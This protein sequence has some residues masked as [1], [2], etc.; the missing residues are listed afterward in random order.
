MWHFNSL[1]INHVEL[2]NPNIQYHHLSLIEYWLTD[3]WLIKVIAL[4]IIKYGINFRFTHT[5]AANSFLCFSKL[6]LLIQYYYLSINLLQIPN[7]STTIH[8]YEHPLCV[9][10]PLQI[11]KRMLRHHTKY[12]PTGFVNCYCDV[13]TTKA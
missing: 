5:Q 1:M 8:F 2:R 12:F 4:D 3:G 6:L 9:P 13:G 7:S 10:H 11:Q